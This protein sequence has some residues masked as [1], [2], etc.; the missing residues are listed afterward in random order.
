MPPRQSGP[1]SSAWVPAGDRPAA[2][3]VAEQGTRGGCRT[4]SR[5]LGTSRSPLP[6]RSP[7]GAGA[8]PHAW[9]TPSPPSPSRPRGWAS[10]GLTAPALECSPA[11]RLISA[12]KPSRRM[13]L[14]CT[15]RRSGAVAIAW[16]YPGPGLALPVR[17]LRT[18]ARP[19]RLS[20]CRRHQDEHER[21]RAS[22]RPSR[23]ER[24][25]PLRSRWA[26]IA[27]E[28]CSALGGASM[29]RASRSGCRRALGSRSPSR[30]SRSPRAASQFKARR[31][32]AVSR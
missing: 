4:T 3:P 19:S 15:L 2:P 27:L 22:S 8:R 28:A 17:S 31:R 14:A 23:S 5:A 12:E 32:L 10:S 30:I 26:C 16:A 24:W 21:R 13:N 18:S 6:R 7:A 29:L 25:T 11:R 20:C 1:S 9:R